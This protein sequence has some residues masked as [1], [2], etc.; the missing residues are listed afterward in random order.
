M[1]SVRWGIHEA[2]LDA[3]RG[4]GRYDTAIETGTYRGASTAVLACRFRE[5]ISIEGDPD[6]AAAAMARLARSANVRVLEGD[7]RTLLPGIVDGLAAPA[8]FWLD[9]HYCG[10]GT[11]GARDQ[12]PVIDE[13]RAVVGSPIPHV[14]LVDDARLFL[15]PPPRALETRQW[16]SI[17]GI[18]RAI[19]AGRVRRHVVVH[20][21]VIAAIPTDSFARVETWLLDVADARFAA[22]ERSLRA[23]LRR[24]AD[25]IRRAARRLV[26]TRPG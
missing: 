15:K 9:S 11:F 26:G 3:V 12:C 24:M 21:D 16:P 8:L 23:R 13:L 5:V 10:R 18:C 25:R 1:G 22:G 20:D 2:F 4:A 14:I 6:L 7:S 19:D 17:D